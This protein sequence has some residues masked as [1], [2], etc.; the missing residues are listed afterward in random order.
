[1]LWWHHFLAWLRGD[2]DFIVGA[3][4]KL[5]AKLEAEV[6]YQNTVGSSHLTSAD[7]A[8]QAARDAERL[9]HQSFEKAQK[10]EATAAKI[11]ALVS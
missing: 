11:K 9:A 7:L 10:A 3:F 2:Y 5:I 8:S 1:M 6:A 4:H